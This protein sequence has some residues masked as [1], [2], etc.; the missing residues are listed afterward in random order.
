[1]WVCKTQ[2]KKDG[3]ARKGENDGWK[4]SVFAK[5]SPDTPAPEIGILMAAPPEAEGVGWWARE[6][7]NL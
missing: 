6:E 5:A 2:H 3:M 1:M 4:K 7:L